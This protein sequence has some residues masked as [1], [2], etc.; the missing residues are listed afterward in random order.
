[1]PE[2]RM[3]PSLKMVSRIVFGEPL[4]SA[5]CSRLV[6]FGAVEG[7]VS[8]LAFCAMMK[9][10]A[11]RNLSAC[12]CQVSATQLGALLA[13]ASSLFQKLFG[14][15]CMPPAEISKYPVRSPNLTSTPAMFG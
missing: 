14:V 9:V 10:Q 3:A 15:F 5:L 1:M 8:G 11:S 4:A 6:A 12:A 13:L 2:S 7:L